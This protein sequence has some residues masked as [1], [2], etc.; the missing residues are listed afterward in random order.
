MSSNVRGISESRLPSH[1]V[2]FDETDVDEA[3]LS[4]SPEPLTQTKVASQHIPSE[5]ALLSAGLTIC[6]LPLFIELHS[7]ISSIK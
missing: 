3:P 4:V 1:P 2:E 7:T 6:S 5:G